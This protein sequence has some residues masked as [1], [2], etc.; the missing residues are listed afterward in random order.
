MSCARCCARLA[1]GLP[2]QGG[3]WLLRG[4]AGVGKSCLSETLRRHIASRGGLTLCARFSEYENNAL[5][6]L[7]SLLRQHVLAGVEPVA[8]IARL[9]QVLH[10]AGCDVDR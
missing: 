10:D 3:G 9:T 4:E 8:Q 1:A 2:G 6:P 7:L 5:S